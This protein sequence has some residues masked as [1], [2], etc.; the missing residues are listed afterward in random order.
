MDSRVPKPPKPPEK[1]LM[2]YMRYSRRV[3]DHVKAQNPELKLWELG[4][5]IGQMWRDL[6]DESKQIYIDDYEA[7]RADYSEQLKTYHSSPAYQS[8]VSA[9]VRAQQAAD[10][11]EQNEKLGGRGGVR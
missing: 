8:Y 2:P 9:K 4:K 11:R 3:W 5:L 1:P 6:S 10:E 7:E